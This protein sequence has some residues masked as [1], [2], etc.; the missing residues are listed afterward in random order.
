MLT[1]R[2]D[3]VGT[4]GIDCI[5]QQMYD[6]NGTPARFL[7]TKETTLYV[8]AAAASSRGSRAESSKLSEASEPPE[9]PNGILVIDIIYI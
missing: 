5:N 4:H 7:R 2:V 9:D 6:K 1:H 8:A 3:H